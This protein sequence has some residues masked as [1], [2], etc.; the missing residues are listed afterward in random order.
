MILAALPEPSRTGDVLMAFLS[1]VF[2]GAPYILV[3]TLLSGLIDAFLPAKLLDRVLPRSKVLSTLMAGFLG[4]VFPVCECAVVPVI[5]R[6]VQKGLPVS[7]AITYMLS[8]PIMN[9]IVAVSTLTAFKEFQKIDGFST[10]GNATMTISRLSLGYVVAVIVG[11]IVLRFAASQILRPAIVAGIATAGDGGHQHGSGPD[12]NAR[13]VQAMRTAMR[14]FLDTG[15]YFTIGVIITSVFNTQVNQALLD[16]VA[17]REYFAIPS[18]MALAFV[19]SLCSTSDAFIA[20]PMGAFSNAA[21]LAFLTFGPMMDVKLIFMY[22][23]VFRR[24]V[25]LAMLIGLFLLVGAL[26]VPWMDLISQLAVKTKP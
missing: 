3:G 5:R 26:A 4:L 6:L 1:I 19:L 22:S 15:M 16:Q 9:P 10:I 2:E 17:T 23:A 14:D 13:L 24:R 8:A 12:F 18:L 11:L 25:V 7:C 21:K 20:A